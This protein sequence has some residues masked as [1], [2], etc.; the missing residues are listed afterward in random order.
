[1]KL[2][3]YAFGEISKQW[4]E[5]KSNILSKISSS[6][7]YKMNIMLVGWIDRS[8]LALPLNLVT[9]PLTF[10]TTP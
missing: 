8:Q 10:G 1:M 3:V 7:L 2:H 6:K 5:Y 9:W 4:A